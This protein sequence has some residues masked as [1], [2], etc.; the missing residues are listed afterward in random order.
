MN[1]KYLSFV[2]ALLSLLLF[3]HTLFGQSTAFS[4]QGSLQNGASP[5]S[6]NHDFE[7]A[8]FDSLVGGSQIGSTVS[9]NSVGVINGIFSVQI[10]FGAAF[11]GAGRFLEI[12]VRA[13]GQPGFTTLTPRR[14]IDSSPYAIKSLNA[15]IAAN[16]TQLGGIAASQYVVTTDP[17]MTDARNP[18]PGSANY[19]WN[20]NSV[21]QPSSNFI[22]SGNGFIGGL[23]ETGAVNI[24]GNGTVGG[25]LSANAVNVT[26]NGTVSG[27]LSSNAF[28]STTQYNI[29]G[30]R[31]LGIAGTGNLFAG[32]GAGSVNTGSSNSFFG[33]FAGFANTTGSNN[34]MLGAGA[35][36]GVNNL[37]NA[38]AIGAQS[39]VN[40]SNCLVLGRTGANTPNVGIGTTAPV[41][42]LE[43]IGEN[44]TT[45]HVFATSYGSINSAI[46]GRQADGTSAAPIPTTNGRTLLFLG[47]RGYADGAFAATSRGGIGIEASQDWTAT[48]NGTR[49]TFETTGNGTTSRSERMRIDHTGRVGIGTATPVVTLDVEGDTNAN[50]YRI[51]G[52]SVLRF[53][54][55][56]NNLIVGPNLVTLQGSSNNNTFIGDLA[57]GGANMSG[58]F[59]TAIGSNTLINGGETYATAVGAGTTV[60]ASNRIQLGRD[61]L[62][63]VRIGALAAASSAQLCISQSILSQCVSSGRYKEN[64]KPFSAGLNLVNRLNPVTYDWIESKEADLGLIAEEVA[65]VEPLLATYNHKG[66]VQ[67]VK[68]DQIP[69]A[70]FNAVREQQQQIEELRRQ[71][72]DLKAFICTLNPSLNSCNTEILPGGGSGQRRN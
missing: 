26:G 35:D 12:R 37:N 8:L 54:S 64:I 60:S 36:V 25:I 53:I 46:I 69:L 15:D 30:A 18:L 1:K 62:D 28:N 71:V 51:G 23:L 67:G 22:V 50:G 34:T 49:I 47:G 24:S 4:Y 41:A 66:E 27:T 43:I 21:L 45:P 31:V 55:A 61:G 17:R 10:D 65:E 14:P 52:T 40:C 32:V 5:T 56:S 57:G 44:N 29:G 59:N 38:T 3:A 70:L 11:P 20:Q 16:A 58:D 19:I 33:A 9:V 6:G 48:G 42:R 39:Q 7:F 2:T 68:Y 13:A 63:T 72:E